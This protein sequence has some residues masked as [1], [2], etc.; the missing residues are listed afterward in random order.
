MLLYVMMISFIESITA[1]EFNPLTFNVYGME[2]LT[3]G[4]LCTLDKCA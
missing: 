2:K 3:D 1:G 4:V